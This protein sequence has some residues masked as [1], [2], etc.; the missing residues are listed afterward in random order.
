[1]EQYAK[2]L[3]NKIA[4]LHKDVDRLSEAGEERVHGVHGGPIRNNRTLR[5][6]NAM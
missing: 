4:E 3:R 2:M 6:Y 1:M 5:R